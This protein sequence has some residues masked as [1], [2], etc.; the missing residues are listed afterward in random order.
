M[1]GRAVLGSG[2]PPEICMLIRQ[3]LQRARESLVLSTELHLTYLCVPV[4]DD[5][6]PNWQHLHEIIHNHLS[7]SFEF[8]R[9]F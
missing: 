3:D 1:F 6:I 2:L 9:R 8:S 4:S 5:V 7:V